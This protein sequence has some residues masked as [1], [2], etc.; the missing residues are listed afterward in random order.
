MGSALSAGWLETAGVWVGFAVTLLIFSALFGD[1]LLARF[2]HYVLVG[3]VLGYAVVVVW[4]SI[5]GLELVAALR[6]DP[7]G[8][9]WQ[10]TPVVLAAI[11]ALAGLERIFAQGRGQPA[12]HGWRAALRTIGAIPALGLVALGVAVAL[13]GA[14]QGTL[15]P[16]FLYAAQSSL[17]WGAAPAEFA[18]GLLTLLLASAALLFFVLDPAHHLANQP[19]W[20]QRLMGGWLWIGQRAVWVAAGALFARLFAAR[21]ALLITEVSGW[22]WRFQLTGLGELFASWW[23]MVTGA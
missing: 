22:L 15:A 13:V 2:A 19:A 17:T 14:V 4:Q 18:A 12:P 21:L 8:A 16:Q 5:L 1:H 9:P 3:A 11:M 10:W 6:A 7:W 20:V 23:R